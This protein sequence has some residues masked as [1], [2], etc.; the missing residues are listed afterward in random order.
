MTNKLLGVLARHRVAA[1]LL[2][3]MMIIAGL[4]GLSRLNTQ[5]FPNFDIDF[6]SVE[7]SWVGASAEDIEKLVTNPIEQEL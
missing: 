3:A 6:I 7:V 1:N 5:F 2:M 4:W